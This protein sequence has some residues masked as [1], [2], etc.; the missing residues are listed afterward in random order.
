LADVVWPHIKPPAPIPQQQHAA[1]QE[2]SDRQADWQWDSS[3]I[4]HVVWKGGHDVRRSPGSAERRRIAGEA[5]AVRETS[6]RV[7]SLAHHVDHIKYYND[8]LERLVA[9]H[10]S[11]QEMTTGLLHQAPFERDDARFR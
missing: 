6:P 5:S 4:D 2:A 7:E 8:P 11:D 9:I 3:P 10:R 1:G